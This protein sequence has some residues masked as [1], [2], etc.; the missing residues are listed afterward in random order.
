MPL[1]RGTTKVNDECRCYILLLLCARA[2]TFSRLMKS[3]WQRPNAFHFFALF[4]YSLLTVVMTYPLAFRLGDTLLGTDSNALNDTYFS[5]W[6]F[7][8]QAHQL[9]ADPLNL[10]QGNI[11]YPFPN[12]LAFSEIIFPAALWYLPLEYATGNPIFAYNLVVLLTFPLNAFAMYVC[13]RDWL[14]NSN[15]EIR[16]LNLAA[17]VAGLVFAFCTYKMGELRHVQLLMGMFMPLTLLYVAHFLRV[18]NFH[19]A[20]LTALFF[21]LNA[22][23]SLYYAVFLAFAVALYVGIDLWTRRFRLTRAHVLYGLGAAAIFVLL[24]APLLL[25]YLRL[26]REHNFSK[27]RDPRLFS[28]RPASYL[29]APRSQ[30]LYGEVTNGFRV[31][32]KGQPLFP[33]IVAVG[34]ALLGLVMLIRKKSGAWIFV[35]LLALMGFVLSFGPDLM[36]DRTN[37]AGLNFPLP[38]F[39]LAKIVSPLNS[40]NAPAR[41]V[42]LT[43]LALALLSAYGIAELVRRAPRFANP[44]VFVCAAL[45]LLEYIPAPLVLAEVDAGANISPA[46]TFLAQQPRGQPVVELPMGAPNFVDQDKHVVYTYNSLYH[47]Q[48]LVNGYSTFIPPDYYALVRDV[49]A[50]P[51]ASAMRR[52]QAWGARWLVVHSERYPDAASLRRQLAKRKMLEHVQD[53]NE[54]WLYR[55][56]QPRNSEP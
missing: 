53:W 45:I 48:P 33:G 44:I 19:N 54:I 17:F 49:Q 21:A 32:S 13:A 12:T 28:A 30:W 35:L 43:M 31:A 2:I 5:V 9:I 22:V 26:E 14:A 42:I 4:A 15:L 27:G 46:Y 10:F 34:L 50:F 6:I 36:L 47:W 29:A 3:L 51:K 40:L 1:P 38:Y 18:P 24:V 37:A 56:V 8:W 41:F 39:A 25:P 52:L 55:V 16:T 11:F 7:G 23:S 20:F